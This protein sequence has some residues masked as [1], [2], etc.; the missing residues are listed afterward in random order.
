MVERML[1]TE[2]GKYD[3]MSLLDL[4]D[5]HQ[6]WELKCCATRAIMKK[7][8]KIPELIPVA[9]SLLLQIITPFTTDPS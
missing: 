7:A 5:S 6:M 4:A 8:H 3:A 2:K 9:K 1:I